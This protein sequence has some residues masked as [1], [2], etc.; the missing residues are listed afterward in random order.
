MDTNVHRVVINQFDH[1][2]ENYIIKGICFISYSNK[3]LIQQLFDFGFLCF[4]HSKNDDPNHYF[5]GITTI[6]EALKQ[7]GIKSKIG[8]M[9]LKSRKVFKY[10]SSH[11]ILFKIK[12]KDPEHINKSSYKNIGFTF[13]D[14]DNAM[15]INEIPLILKDKIFLTSEGYKTLNELKDYNLIFTK[16]IFRK[17]I[18]KNKK[19]AFITSKIDIQLISIFYDFKNYYSENVFYEYLISELMN[20][21][22]K[23][24]I[25][26]DIIKPYNVKNIDQLK[27]ILKIC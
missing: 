26:L 24:F 23:N 20:D 14:N 2:P 13:L 12:I 9:K 15:E 19:T 21:K 27:E 11:E 16:A 3:K 10:D 7:N 18:P 5:T 1:L 22:I 4:Q 17:Y 6:Q 25:Y 8:T